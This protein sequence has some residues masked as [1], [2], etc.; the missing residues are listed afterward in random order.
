MTH[1]N[2]LLDDGNDLMI[3][4]E[5]GRNYEGEVMPDESMVK[6]FTYKSLASGELRDLDIVPVA[7]GYDKRIEEMAFPFLSKANGRT[8][9]FRK[10]LYYG[11]DLTAF[12]AWLLARQ[13]GFNK[14]VNCYINFG[15]SINLKEFEKVPEGR[16]WSFLRKRVVEDVR[17]LYS[18]IEAEKG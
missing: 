17:R 16:R 6:K 1:F 13:L 11:A 14:D 7:I 12:A 15:E 8:N 18:E 2:G 3:F 5:G 10:S 4:T 9:L